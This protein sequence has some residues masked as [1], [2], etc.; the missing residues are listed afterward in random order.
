VLDVGGEDSSE[1]P[2]NLVRLAFAGVICGLPLVGVGQHKKP[3]GSVRTLRGS[4]SSIRTRKSEAARKL[5]QTKKQVK[6]VKGDLD[7]VD[8]RLDKVQT[9]LEETSDRLT[10]GKKEQTSLGQRLGIA[11]K[12]F[13]S[14]KDKVRKRIRWMYVHGEHSF[15]SVLI[16]TK[17][18]GDLATQQY[19][20]GRIAERDRKVF[21]DYLN[22]R[23]EIAT[24]K[25]RQDHLVVEIKGLAETQKG[26]QSQLNDVRK[27]KVE[28]LNDL[29]QQQ[30]ELLKVIRQLEADE[31]SIENQIEAYLRAQRSSG[32][33]VG[34]APK[35]RFG[36]PCSG[37]ITSG[38]GMRFHPIL[39]I[40][41]LHAGID[42][43]APSGA[44]IYAANTGVV[45]AAQKMRGFGNVVMIDHGG[46]ITTVY[47][48]CSRIFVSSGQRVIRGQRVASVGSTG[49][50]TGPHLHFE[51]RINGRAVDPRRYL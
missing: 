41:R 9:A 32:I 51:V 27:E 6:R 47:G 10:E 26:Q 44:P 17:T 48:H 11:A 18:V 1:V 4:L 12:E 50:A 14:T 7:E 29:R 37:P 5:N 23:N 43:G 39:H 20:L 15:V 22:L 35:G 30:S 40:R 8:N 21:T 45:I 31:A 49:L 38:F 2:V 33:P 28:V 19:V 13:E 34:P 16:G 42:F 25:N 24:K 36:R 3:T 46:G